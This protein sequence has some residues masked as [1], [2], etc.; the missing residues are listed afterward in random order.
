MTTKRK[1]NEVTLKQSR[2]HWKS[3]R[4]IDLTK[5]LP[6]S[7]TFLEVH[8]LLWKKKQGKNLPSFSKFINET[9][10]SQSR[11]TWNNLF[12]EDSGFDP[13]ISKF[14]R[15]INQGKR[16]K[17]RQSSTNNFFTQQWMY[18]YIVKKFLKLVMMLHISVWHLNVS[19]F[20]QFGYFPLFIIFS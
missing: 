12:T 5:K 14:N 18:T 8:L 7:S 9:T 10:K 13:L 2:K 17:M 16:D 6:F 1:Y 15:I 3:L 11:N 20:Q 19:H 4:K